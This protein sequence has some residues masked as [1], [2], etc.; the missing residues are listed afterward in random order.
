MMNTILKLIN[1]INDKIVTSIES[2]YGVR[3]II[4]IEV[5]EYIHNK[6]NE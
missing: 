1:I 6:T 2:V 5:S 4:D 3:Y